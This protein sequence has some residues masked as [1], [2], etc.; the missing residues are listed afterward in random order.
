VERLSQ[1][2]TANGA[3]IEDL[4]ASVQAFASPDLLTDDVTLLIVERTRR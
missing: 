2:S 3:T 4:I 1:L